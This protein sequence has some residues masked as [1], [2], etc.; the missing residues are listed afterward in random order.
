[1][2]TNE[3]KQTTP[4]TPRTT[5]TTTTPPTRCYGGGVENDDEARVYIYTPTHTLTSRRRRVL[6][7]DRRRPPRTRAHRDTHAR[8]PPRAWCTSSIAW[9]LECTCIYYI[10]D[11]ACLTM[12]TQTTNVPRGISTPRRPPWFP[13]RRRRG[14]QKIRS[15]AREKVCDVYTERIR[16]VRLKTKIKRGLRRVEPRLLVEVVVC[17]SSS[18]WWVVDWFARA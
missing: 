3:F 9:A 6:P 15:K 2:N 17:S 12:N 10:G 14:R 4:R 5:P 13:S 8:Q 16:E 7:R 1:M 11:I 18:S